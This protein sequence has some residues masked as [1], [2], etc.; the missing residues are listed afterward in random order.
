METEPVKA[1]SED[2]KRWIRK[3]ESL[4][5]QD[6]Y[7]YG[8]SGCI[9]PPRFTQ[10]ADRLRNLEV[11][12]DDVWLV[13]F[14]RS[15]THW[16]SEMIWLIG[17]KLDWNG[18]KEVHQHQR[19]P[20]ADGQMFFDFTG[21]EREAKNLDNAENMKSPR[22]LRAHL[23]Y[24]LLPSGLS[25]KK[26]KMIYICRDVRDVAVSYYY[27][28]RN[29]LSKQY[30]G[31]MDEF[32][33]A[34]V[35]DS[36]MLSPYWKHVEDFWNIRNEP[37]VLFLTYEEMKSDLGKVIR[38]VAEFLQV[39]LTTTDVEQLKRHLSFEAMFGNRAVNLETASGVGNG[40]PNSCLIRNGASGSWKHE[41]SPSTIKSLESWISKNGI[42]GFYY[43]SATLSNP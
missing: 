28:F 4:P 43:N 15:G 35:A 39:D 25:E 26:P 9:L 17:N 24:D 22:Y 2:T 31:T 8:A 37:N 3:F 20:S 30:T 27:L 21:Q 11:R 13:G 10:I 34:F 1:E 5:F 41:L 12:D 18:A 42:P 32:A 7:K 16:V 40:D 33:L 23:P 38:N 36:V 19:F 29:F 6:F 14:P